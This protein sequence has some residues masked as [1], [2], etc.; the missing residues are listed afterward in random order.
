MQADWCLAGEN[1]SH[2][3]FVHIVFSL[4]THLAV[5]S[6]SPRFTY[7][8]HMG[9]IRLYLGHSVW[10]STSTVEFMGHRVPLWFRQYATSLKVAGSRINHVIKFYEFI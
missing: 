9:Y 7:C 3:C 8:A 5:H 6:G 1:R 4:E 10:D 2:E